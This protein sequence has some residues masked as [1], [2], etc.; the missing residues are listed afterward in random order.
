MS[1]DMQSVMQGMR[2]M[3]EKINEI[4][5]EMMQSRRG[6]VT[7][8]RARG[9]SRGGFSLSSRGRGWGCQSC[10]EHNRGFD[11]RHCFR[12]GE[13][14]HRAYECPKATQD[15]LNLEGLGI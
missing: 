6:N 3:K 5:L 1:A 12:C 10:R 11:C 7:Y 8:G 2:E 9:G 4:Q 13:E 14:S 15:P